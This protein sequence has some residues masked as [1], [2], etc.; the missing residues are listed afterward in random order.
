[1]QEMQETRVASLGWEDLLKEEMATHSGILAWRIPWTAEPGGLPL[2]RP[3]RV[4]HDRA[5]LSA[6]GVERRPEEMGWPRSLSWLVCG[7]SPLPVDFLALYLVPSHPEPGHGGASPGPIPEVSSC[8][9][10]CIDPN[11]VPICFQPSISPKP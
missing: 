11:E 10:T 4:R 6:P 8:L 1:M 7:C 9:S 3:Q 5:H 2:M